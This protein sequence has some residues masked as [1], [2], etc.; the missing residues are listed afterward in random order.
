MGVYI[1]GNMVVTR[2]PKTFYFYFDLPKD[3]D[4]NLKHGIT[5][6]IK[7]NG[8]LAEHKIKNEIS[9]LLHKYN[10][11]NEIPEHRKQWNKSA[12]HTSS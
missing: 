2:E 6:L 12:T 3:V 8:S 7:H 1:V 4:K 11:A 5:F 10:H 9:Q